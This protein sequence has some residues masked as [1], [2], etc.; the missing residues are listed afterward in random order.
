MIFCAFNFSG[1]QVHGEVA[2]GI[3]DHS[4]RILPILFLLFVTFYVLL[5]TGV[6]TLRSSSDISIKF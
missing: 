2:A 6:F 5:T 4:R 3:N 1:K